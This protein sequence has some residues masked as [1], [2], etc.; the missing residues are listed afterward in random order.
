M[1][2][3]GGEVVRIFEN[4]GSNLLSIFLDILWEEEDEGE[5]ERSEKL[6]KKGWGL[7]KRNIKEM[8]KTEGKGGWGGILKV[9]FIWERR[10]EWNMETL[11]G[12]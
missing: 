8:G 1:S 4:S 10:K 5:R 2:R 7:G 11:R 6:K 9:S 12:G 3:R